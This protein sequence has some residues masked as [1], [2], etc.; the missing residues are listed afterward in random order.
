MEIRSEPPGGWWKFL[1]EQQRDA[2]EAA[3]K[4]VDAPSSLEKAQ[5]SNTV[6]AIKKG[7][8]LPTLKP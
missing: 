5:P 1:E 6:I 7:A 8:G 2:K 3:D 4:N